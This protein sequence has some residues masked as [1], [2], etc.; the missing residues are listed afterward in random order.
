[1]NRY[2]FDLS[3]KVFFDEH[4]RWP[5]DDDYTEE[6][7]FF[8]K[9]KMSTESMDRMI[10]YIRTG[11]VETEEGDKGKGCG[12]CRGSRNRFKLLI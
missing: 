3:E 11:V 2:E 8:I 5:E 6:Q 7:I 12:G 4:G 9:N 10:E 1:M